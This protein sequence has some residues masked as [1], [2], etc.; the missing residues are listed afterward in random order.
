[1]YMNGLCIICKAQ[2]FMFHLFYKV[3]EWRDDIHCYR[4]SSKILTPKF[5]DIIK[6]GFNY[7]DVYMA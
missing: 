3:S 1:M 7:C 2:K 4:K 5:L 6:D